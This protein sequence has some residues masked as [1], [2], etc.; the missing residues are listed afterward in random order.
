MNFS[1]GLN[2]IFLKTHIFPYPNKMQIN[3]GKQNLIY[4]LNLHFSSIWE[5]HIIPSHI[6]FDIGK[7]IEDEIN[8]SNDPLFNSR[9]LS[10]K[11]ITKSP[12][13]SEG[14]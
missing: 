7:I 9:K 11:K 12:T 14:P 8:K 1:S 5:S 2:A 3:S 10:N 6:F 4:L 13:L